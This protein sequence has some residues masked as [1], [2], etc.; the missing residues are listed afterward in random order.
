MTCFPVQSLSER[1]QSDA[2]IARIAVVLES[3]NSEE[4]EHALNVLAN[5]VN[6]LSEERLQLVL[7]AFIR[8]AHSAVMHGEQCAVILE[9]L[10][11]TRSLLLERFQT[12]RSVS[13]TQRRADR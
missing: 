4:Q 6:F 3:N 7:G 10:I 11:G 12:C 8:F 13:A 5:T 9:R 1:A 2:L